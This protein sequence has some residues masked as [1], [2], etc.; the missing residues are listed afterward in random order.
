MSAE[1]GVS[2]EGTIYAFALSYRAACEEVQ[3]TWRDVFLTTSGAPERQVAVAIY[4]QACVR[5]RDLRAALLHAASNGT[6]EVG[7]L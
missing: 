4:V 6:P 1:L 2:E 7:G 5:A 3:Q